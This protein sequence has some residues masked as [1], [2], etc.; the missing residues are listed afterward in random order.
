MARFFI[1]RPVFAWVISIIIMLAGIM[2][3]RALPVAQYPDIA[4]PNISI[5][6]NYQGASAKAVEDSVT[7]VIEQ[8][9]TGLDG[10]DYISSSSSSSGTSE[11]TV[12]FVAGTDPDIAQV[13]VQNKLGLATPLLPEPVQQQGV[14]VD[15]AAPGFLL[16]TALHSENGDYSAIDLADYIYANLYDQIARTDGVGYVRVFGSQY[17]MRVWLNPD[18]LV[19]YGLVP[20]DISNALREQ[21]TQISAGS[22]GGAPSVEGQDISVTVTVQSLLNT[23]EEF[24]NLLIKTTPEGGSVRLRDVARVEKGTE[25]YAFKTAQDNKPASGF[26]VSLAAGA[27]A[28]NTAEAVKD[29]IE[30]MSAS[31]PEGVEYSFP[32]DS[33]PFIE[34]SI[35]EVQKTLIEAI[36]LVFLVILI[37]LQSLRASFVPMIAVPVVLLG[38]FAVLWTFGMSIN[39]LTMFAMVLAIG[40]LV[41]DAIVVVENVERVMEEDG[42][43]PLEATRKSM[44]QITGA[45]VGIAVVLS[46]VFVPM[47]FFP[48][49]TGI[50]Y[51]Q[52]SVTIVSAMLLSV[53]V[54][55]VLS[56]ALCATLLKPKHGDGGILG[57][58]AR[59]FNKGFDKMQDGYTSIVE[60]IVRRRWIFMVVF[61]LLVGL[62]GSAFVRLPSAF[63][64]EEDQANMF[65]M[66]QLPQNSS[67]ERTSEVLEDAVNYLN[68]EEADNVTG[69]FS[70]AG[71]NFMGQGENN[72]TVF[73]SLADWSEREGEENGVAA[74]VNRASAHFS[75]ST[76]ARI[77]AVVPPAIREL[78]NA[79]GF[80]MYLQ[81]TGGLSSEAFLAARNQLLG[82]AS[83]DPALMAV[84]PN[85]I[86]DAPQLNVDLDFQKAQ[87][88][89]VAPSSATSVLS[90]AFGGTYVNDFLDRGRIKRVYVQGDAE[91]RMQPEDL[92][93]WYARNES[94]EM[95]P[96]EELSTVEWT[97]GSP[98]LKRYNGFSS[99][100][101]QGMPSPG[102][103][104]GD[105]M[106]AMERIVSQLP[107]GVSFEW[108]GLSK[109]EQQSGNQA[110]LLYAISVLFVFLCLAALYESWTVPVAVILVAPLGI[111]GAVAAAHIR[112]LENNVFFQVGLLTTV[113]LASKN[114]ILIVEFAKLLEEQGKGL[115]EAT[116]ESVRMRLRPILMTSFAFGFGVIPL[117]LSHGAGSGGR[118]AVGTIVLGGVIASTL[119]GIFFAPLFYVFVRKLTGAKPLKPVGSSKQE[120][121]A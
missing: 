49:S 58:P 8:Q 46:A 115:I 62:M 27:N 81:N 29:V 106:A 121:G 76:E 42:L 61:L 11:I 57:T 26:A 117:A 24:E 38:T 4:P 93:Y 71:F 87:A 2:A 91:Y 75:Q 44:D 102:T 59:L 113:G 28:L 41:D 78:G 94:G 16:I 79:S 100:N 53:L 110:P 22:V 45:L 67:L 98:L 31:F 105:A 97:Y 99:Y 116:I 84:R 54:A 120:Q 7:Q 35:H 12:T 92:S 108:T 30:E 80:D 107:Q 103:S 63:L 17:A 77:F 90:T 112:G 109:Q 111:L 96:L 14:T 18:K 36:I 37:F 65:A 50:I 118:I 13:Q 101:I 52:F 83:Q 64:P 40:L 1:D 74:I 68:E 82:M 9:M 21:N 119:F 47:A 10:L 104:S 23:V 72:G 95:T 55:I 51:R 60:R 39:T 34:T 88:L 15:K 5:R 33:T 6:A 19:E 85:G 48:G 20:S 43:P 70:I 3:V 56:P 89:G 73:V 69:V 32:V 66:I 114:A 86:E 25:H